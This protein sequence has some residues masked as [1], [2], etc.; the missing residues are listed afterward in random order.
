MTVVN[1]NTQAMFANKALAQ[2]HRLQ[3]ESSSQ[4]A[5][6]KRV[7]SASDDAAGSAISSKLS[8]QVISLNM[9]VRNS[10]DGIS[11]MQTA[12][13]AA[14]GIQ[15]ILH[16]MRELALQANNGTNSDH[17][18]NSMSDEFDKLQEQITSTVANTS[19]NGMKLLDGSVNVNGV[20]NYHVG[21]TADDSIAVKFANFNLASAPLMADRSIERTVGDDGNPN[22]KDAIVSIDGAIEQISNARATWGS[23]MNTLVHAA[24]SATNMSM[25]MSASYSR[26]VDTDY[27]QATADLAKSLILDHAGTAM[28]SQANQQPGYVLALLS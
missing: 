10:N 8:T 13:G 27:A 4:L 7:N 9:A 22:A 19:W 1:T 14:S 28:L 23:A 3:S 18:I 20:A 24:S 6:G 15:D 16:R 25:N 12:D 5:T 26:I 11:M 17:E 2:S 21:A